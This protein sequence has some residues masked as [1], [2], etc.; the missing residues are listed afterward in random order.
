MR[1]TCRHIYRVYDSRDITFQRDKNS[2]RYFRCVEE[3]SGKLYSI[4][5]VD[6]F[7]GAL[8]FNL[9]LWFYLWN[10]VQCLSV[11][12]SFSC[13][14]CLKFSFTVLTNLIGRGR[15]KDRTFSLRVLRAPVINLPPF[16]HS[17]KFTVKRYL[18]DVVKRFSWRQQNT[19][20]WW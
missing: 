1:K 10:S 5:D 11:N 19:I 15:Y 3:E 7:I 20:C 12:L 9:C 16:S 8:E 13:I 2:I 6:V 18:L 17:Q 4:C 14:A